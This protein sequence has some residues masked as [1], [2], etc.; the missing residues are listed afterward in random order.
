AEVPKLVETCTRL[1]TGALMGL[2]AVIPAIAAGASARVVSALYD[3][4]E[5][6][7]IGLQMLDDLSGLVSERRSAKGHE[8]LILGRPTWPW[9]WLATDLGPDEYASLQR[10]ARDVEGGACHPGLLAQEIRDSLG[11]LSRRR[12]E[13]HFAAAKRGLLRDVPGPTGL[14]ELERELRKLMGSYA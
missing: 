13:A 8:D 6:L 9:A 11:P 7:G 1:K 2:A 3:F 12:I 14:Q 10:L 4:G 5:Q